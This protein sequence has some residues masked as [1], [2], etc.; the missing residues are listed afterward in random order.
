MIRGLVI[1]TMLLGPSLAS[2]DRLI[3]GPGDAPEYGFVGNARPDGLVLARQ[4]I[5]AETTPIVTG[6]R[7]VAL[8]QSRVVYLNKGGVTLSPGSNDS[9]A[10]RSTVV[11]Q[12]T[13]LAGWNPTPTTW[14]ETVTCMRELFSQFDVVITDVDPGNVPHIEAVFGGT[15][16][17]V[18]M[19][20]SVAGVSPFTTDCSII[21]NSVV[22]TF[23]NAFSFTS[24]EACEIMAQEVAHSYGL[25]H[26]L[27]ASDPMTYLPYT[28]NRSFQDTAAQC[29][30]DAGAPRQCGINGNV[31][32]PTQNSV[33]LLRERLGVAD[34][35]MP[36]IATFSPANRATVPPG[37]QVKASGTDN[38]A[39][40]GATLKIDG[41]EHAQLTG[42]GPF[43]FA[44]PANL[45]EGDHTIVV[46]IS[47][48]KNIKAE[49]RTVTVMIGAPPPEDDDGTSEFGEVS[50]GCSTGGSTGGL[51][52]ALGAFV[53][54]DVSRRHRRRRHP[55]PHRAT[56]AA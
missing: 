21:E 31:C 11:N 40:A 51:V 41:V 55:S 56:P 52:L 5:P 30:E 50:G 26:E 12:Q 6:D 27:L 17:Q 1:A 8:A 13:S 4:V 7:N 25:D 15:P 19:D 33:Q 49:T 53:A 47:D 2:A 18:G 45:A 37:F 35:I 23:T 36:A 20:A 9:R 48:G 43:V 24:R 29:G 34:A 39:I 14:S 10:N 22:F 32:R 46:E 54:L 42:A 16:Q 38:N 44:T 3:Y 28:G